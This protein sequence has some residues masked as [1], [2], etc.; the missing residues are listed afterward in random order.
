MDPP[1]EISPSTQFLLDEIRRRFDE[2]DARME[3]HFSRAMAALEPRG[4]AI[5]LHTGGLT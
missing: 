4:V 3:Q 2:F 5:E 1:T